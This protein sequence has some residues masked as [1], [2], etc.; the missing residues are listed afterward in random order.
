MPLITPSRIVV[1]IIVSFSLITFFWTYG[2]PHQ[3]QQL[4]QPESPAVNHY[5]DKNV[6]SKPIVPPSVG[7][8]THA[9]APKPTA[10]PEQS[11]DHR[12]DGKPKGDAKDKEEMKADQKSGKILHASSS[13]TLFTKATPAPNNANATE[14]TPSSAAIVPVSTHAVEKFC[15]DVAGAP[16]VMVVLKTSKAEIDTLSSRFHTLLSCV[17]HFA[18]FSDHAG[19]FNGHPVHDALDSISDRVKSRHA[20]FDEYQIA[21]AE[22]KPDPKKVKELDKW[23][24][25][26]MVYKAYH[27]KPDARF[28]VF[29]EAETSLSWTNLLQ[30]VNRLDY[31]IPYYSGAPVFNSGTQLAQAGP[32]IMLSQGALRR[33]S[34]SYDELYTSKWEKKL[35]KE[36]CGD[37]MLARAFDDAH[38]EFYSSWPLLQSEQPH[39]LDYT[40]RHWCVPAVSWYHMN[41]ES[42]THQWELEKNWTKAHDWETPYLFRDAFHDYVEPQIEARK[43]GWDN[44]S[45]DAKIVAPEGGQKLKD[46][47]KGDK[48]QQDS[49]T[50]G[51]ADRE[52]E[53]KREGKEENKKEDK[54]QD[55]KEGKKE[56]KKEGKKQ[57]PD[58]DKLAEKYPNAADSV[59]QCL[60]ACE[61]I[62]DCLQW[63]YIAKEEAECH[64]SKVLRLGS[65]DQD[66]KWTS[67]WLIERVKETQKDWEC[68]KVQ[69]KFYQ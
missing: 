57:P 40:K 67:G 39:T 33:Y 69:W 19:E 42:L 45:G 29:I 5:D 41:G 37:L 6:H 64:L 13:S 68:K 38:V 15:K 60:K 36:C 16:H 8:E 27:L 53:A 26:P 2:L 61:Q 24:M 34:K 21:D 63:R 51:T 66:S 9:T 47:A 59:D 14:S 56:D 46:E 62:E 7:K 11:A 12:W 50:K 32:G 31:R 35:G 3:Q 17:P 23:K 20:E 43:K 49:K 58:W 4:A 22:H 44:L 52:K 25:L 65:K 55:E 10:R 1:I 28:F 18:I 54:K 30:W 48:K